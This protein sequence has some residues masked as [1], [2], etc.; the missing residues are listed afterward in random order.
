MNIKMNKFYA[1]VKRLFDKD[2]FSNALSVIAVI[3][4]F[5]LAA[6]TYLQLSVDK[7]TGD[8]EFWRHINRSLNSQQRVANK[9]YSPL[10]YQS[11]MAEHVLKE[12]H[13]NTITCKKFKIY[14]PKFVEN[15]NIQRY[16]FRSLKVQ[17]Y[18]DDEMYDFQSVILENK[19]MAK[20]LPIKDW[21]SVV[22]DQTYSS[23]WWSTLSWDSMHLGFFPVTW[24]WQCAP[25]KKTIKI[26][27]IDL[28]TFKTSIATVI[29]DDTDIEVG[30]IPNIMSLQN[31]EAENMPNTDVTYR[32]VKYYFDNN[33]V[34]TI[35]KELGNSGR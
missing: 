19:Y 11:A 21:N 28:D 20:A 24:E 32:P 22:I 18:E 9:L 1:A 30:D 8:Y 13:N 17:R 5:F 31:L 14:P 2:H 34:K 3:L 10:F 6:Y 12:I 4:S 23:K 7:S 16:I 29:V 25:G 26:S 15:S 33:E 27:P 35:K